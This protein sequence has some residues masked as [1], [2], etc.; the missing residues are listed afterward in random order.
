[1]D[2]SGFGE[3]LTNQTPVTPKRTDTRDDAVVGLLVC[4]VRRLAKDDRTRQ[5]V[6]CKDDGRKLVACTRRRDSV[7]ANYTPGIRPPQSLTR[8]QRDAECVA[9][10]GFPVNG[11][12][13][14][15]HFGG[16]AGGAA[17]AEVGASYTRKAANPIGTRPWRTDGGVRRDVATRPATHSRIS[18]RGSSLASWVQISESRTAPHAR[19][20]SPALRP[21]Y[22]VF[23][24]CS[25]VC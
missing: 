21:F 4:V 2:A 23:S 9:Q 13:C 11:R 5:G 15:H 24:L 16:Q 14:R 25:A 8:D 19:S 17:R 10:T 1:M 6:K 20:R 3:T 22:H 7:S 18:D 12:R